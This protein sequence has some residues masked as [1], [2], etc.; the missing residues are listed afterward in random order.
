M[1]KLKCI[2]ALTM[3][4]SLCTGYLPVTKLDMLEMCSISAN[5]EEIAV[6]GT[7]GENLT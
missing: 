2:L 3:S 5:A 1:K 7:C 4:L 6:S